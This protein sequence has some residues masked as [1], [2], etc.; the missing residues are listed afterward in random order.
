MKKKF[1]KKDSDY[2]VLKQWCLTACDYLLLIDA[3]FSDLVNGKY[4]IMSI[5]EDVDK[6]HNLT[7]LKALNK[8]LIII[9][10]E[11]LSSD[12][13]VRLNQ[14]LKEK[15]GNN[16]ADENNKESETIQKIIKRGKICN[17][18]EFELVKRR[19]EE[20]WQDDSQIEYAETLRHLM[21]DY[22]N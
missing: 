16:I 6:T 15:C 13:M 3:R 10:R 17:D 2:Q 18:R 11:M 22:E 5:L 8:E 9:L 20:I 4:G 14:L 19:E 7:K 21:E 1:L 12:Q